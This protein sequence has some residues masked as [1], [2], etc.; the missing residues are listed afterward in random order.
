MGGCGGTDVL[1]VTIMDCG[2]D[3]PQ[4]LFAVTLID[5]L[6]M[7][8]VALMLVVVEVPVQPLGNVHV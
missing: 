3:D 6:A 8:A 2:G 5:P 4:I 1:T 7:L